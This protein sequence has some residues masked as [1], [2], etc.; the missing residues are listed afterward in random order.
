VEKKYHLKIMEVILVAEVIWEMGEDLL[1]EP[2]VQ[3]D[4]S[5]EEVDLI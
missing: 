1:V 4:L 3:A 2:S 5:V